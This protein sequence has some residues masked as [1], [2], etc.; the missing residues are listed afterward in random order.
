MKPKL[1]YAS[2]GPYVSEAQSKLNVQMPVPP[3][4]AVDGK[5][6]SKTVQRVNQFQASRGLAADGIVGAKTWAALDS[7]APAVTGGASG[8]TPPT[9]SLKV[10]H[11]V[12][13]QGGALTVCSCGYGPAPLRVTE[14]GRTVAVIRDAV[15][16]VN[17][18]SFGMCRSF[19]NPMVA[20]ATSAAMGTLTP[21]P[22]TPAMAGFWS[23]PG[24]PLELA[25]N[26]PAPVLG[27][28]S[29]LQCRFGGTINIISP[30]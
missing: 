22:C 25:G 17:I 7:S 29:I 5:Y 10:A 8:Q 12:R 15:G 19:G 20:A 4:L 18:G 30:G 26:P 11:G 9:P 16:N 21:M 28:N 3:L 27:M 14:P 6:G 13:V 24:A 2:T 23:P 1:E